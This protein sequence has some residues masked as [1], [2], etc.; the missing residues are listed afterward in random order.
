MSGRRDGMASSAAAAASMK[1]GSAGRSDGS[2]RCF[3]K[4]RA[5]PRP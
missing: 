2:V 3:R 4:E 1:K 5:R